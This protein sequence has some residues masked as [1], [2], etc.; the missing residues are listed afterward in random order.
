M[1][2]SEEETVYEGIVEDRFPGSCCHMLPAVA[3]IV[4]TDAQMSS[5]AL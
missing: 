4:T 1:R 2:Y 3:N 5:L